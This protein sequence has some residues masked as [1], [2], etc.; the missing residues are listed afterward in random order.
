M[1]NQVE[2]LLE[3]LKTGEE[4]CF[5]QL[6][7]RYFQRLHFFAYQYV[8]DTATAESLV[9]DTFVTLWKKRESLRCKNENSLLSWLYTVLKNGCYQFIKTEKQRLINLVSE[10]QLAIDIEGLALMDTS[11]NYFNEVNTIVDNTLKM[12]SPRCKEVFEL[13]RYG[14]LKNREIASKLGIT[15]KAVEGNISRA[16]KEFRRSLKEYLPY[17]L[18]I[19]NL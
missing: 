11:E 18:I 13:S 15:E 3:G 5:N 19:L 9:Q 4:K 14:G 16:L 2:F 17:V 6:F 1:L 12:L 7:N 8:R 10:E